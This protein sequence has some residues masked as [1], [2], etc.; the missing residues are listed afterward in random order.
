[1]QMPADHFNAGVQ[2]YLNAIVHNPGESI[3][4]TPLVV[5]LDIGTG[6]YWFAPSWA[7]YPWDVDW[8]TINAE[9]GSITHEII[10]EFTWPDN[11]GGSASG[12]VFWGAMLNPE[13]TQLVGT[14]GY[15]TFGYGPGASATSDQLQLSSRTAAP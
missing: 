3:P 1:M 4:N 5:M 10:P 2:C 11:V 8:L 14:L 13:A 9:H 15:W 7:H 12:I 6:D